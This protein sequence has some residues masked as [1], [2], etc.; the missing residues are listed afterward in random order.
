MKAPGREG[1][2]AGRQPAAKTPRSTGSIFQDLLA[3]HESGPHL[4]DRPAAATGRASQWPAAPV[5]AVEQRSLFGEIL[6][7]MLAPLLLL[8]PLSV[9]VTFV[10]ARSLADAPFDRAL[11]DHANVLAQQAQSYIAGG[12]LPAA[13]QLRD[14]L[15]A[16]NEGYVSFQITAADGEL[17]RGE[18]EFPPPALY[19]FPEAGVVKLRNDTFRGEEVRVAYTY[20]EPEESSSGQTSVLI[21]IAETQDKRDQLANEIIKGVIFPQFVILPLAV[22]LVWFGL[23][24]GLSP[25][26]RVQQRLRDRQPDDLSPID[27]SGVP[28][29]ISP[30]VDAFNE[31]LSRLND[32]IGAQK[33]FI[34]D[35]AHQMKTPLAGLRTQA[36]LALRETDPAEVRR[37]LEQLAISSD[38]AAHLISQLLALARMENLRD[39]AQLEALDLAP[40]ARSVVMEWANAAIRRHIDFGYENDD[41]PA[42]VAGHPILLR[43]LFNNLIDNALRYTPDGGRVTIR[44]RREEGSAVFEVEDSGPGIALAE[45]SLVFERFYRVLDSQSDGSGLG[46]AIVREIATQHGAQVE[47]GGRDPSALA[48]RAAPSAAGHASVSA[49]PVPAASEAAASE[50][51]AAGLAAAGPAA[52]NS[53]AD[54]A[55]DTG[56]EPPRLG[57]LITVKFPP[58]AG[59]T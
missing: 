47:I 7:W 26:Q 51:A 58:L 33:R 48:A 41:E 19:D 15:P 56:D 52:A 23:S 12:A 21:Q 17:L 20:V 31:L 55:I 34:A 53:A 14:L 27:R 2:P 36:E 37:S 44:V 29:E 45:R 49:A 4:A 57:A 50:L 42:P 43:E 59:E 54:D 1:Q 3:T 13:R 22:G 25:L 39:A 28:A 38:R 9:A 8:W 11:V 40:L 32:R 35:A 6:D 30:L 10:V 24:R 46:L 5:G 18:P 16:A